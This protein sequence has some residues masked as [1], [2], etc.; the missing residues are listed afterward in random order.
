MALVEIVAFALGLLLISWSV[1]L[2]EGEEARVDDALAAWW[3]A[4]DDTS[5]RSISLNAT[6]AR[7]LA[8]TVTAWLNAIYG[9]SLL[10]ARAITSSF[11]LSLSSVLL[12][13]SVLTLQAGDASWPT[14]CGGLLSLFLFAAAVMKRRRFVRIIALL[15]GTLG[16]VAVILA[17][18]HRMSLLVIPFF[19]VEDVAL[20]SIGDVAL[21]LGL[22]LVGD[23]AVV[24]F[25]RYLATRTATAQRVLLPVIAALLNAILAVLITVIPLEVGIHFYSGT[26]WLAIGFF[27]AALTNLYA[28]LI[29]ISF[30]PLT[31]T[32]L[33]HRAMWPVLNRSIYSIHRFKL[34][35][36][37]KVL[38]FGG[39]S[40]VA[41]VAPQAGKLLFDAAKIFSP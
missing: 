32:L 24:L 25:T 22:G 31:I 4:L 6:F 20:R 33:L 27:V 2:Y 9:E 40:L 13:V 16:T 19:S 1:F 10:S 18:A 30:L 39:A 11:C 36:Q 12:V 23:F 34:F 17:I 38:F 26:P 29:A 15:L 41:S 7:R 3:V 8:V 5:K 35:Q 37:R 28:C 21:A 14:A